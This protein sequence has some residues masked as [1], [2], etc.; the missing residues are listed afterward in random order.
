MI[1]DD[2][3]LLRETL[4]SF[5]KPQKGFNV[6]GTAATGHEALEQVPTLKPDLILMDLHRPVM[7]G[8]KCSVVA[9]AQPS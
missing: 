6:V 9:R 5:F 4:S 7:D 1:V 2:A 3:A 8:S